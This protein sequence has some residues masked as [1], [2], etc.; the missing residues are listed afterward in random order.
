[1][2]EF[3][4]ALI[5]IATFS[6]APV[7]AGVVAQAE[8]GTHHAAPI[9]RALSLTPAERQQAEPILRDGARRLRDLRGQAHDAALGALSPDHRSRVEQIA[10]ATRG[11]VRALF[12]TRSSAGASTSTAQRRKALHDQIAPITAK[13]AG[14]I[15]A[16]LTPQENQAVLAQRRSLGS[17]RGRVLASTAAQLRPLLTSGQQQKLD[18]WSAKMQQHAARTH[19]VDAGRFLLTIATPPRG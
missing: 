10:A 6:A 14:E 11:Q 1:M 8:T 4:S 17:E 3:L 9:E 15:D 13:G 2:K 19:H 5:I 18:A 7:L 16:L 12:A